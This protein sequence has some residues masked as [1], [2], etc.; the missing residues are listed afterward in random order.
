MAGQV[1]GQ[2][3]RVAERERAASELAVARDTALEASRLKS[4][5]L[6]MMSHEIRTPMNGVIGLNELLLGTRLDPHQRRLAEAAQLSGSALL[7]II[8]DVLDFSKI[9]AG[10]LALEA[11]EFEL[12]PVFDQVEAT[13][14]A[15]AEDKGVDLAVDVAPDVPAW[16]VGDPTRLGQVVSN[17]VSNAV[18]F[19]PAGRVDVHVGVASVEGKTILLEVAVVDTGIGIDPAQLDRL[20]EPFRQ[21]D[22][23]TTRLH[24]GSGLGLAISRRLVTALGGDLRV[25]SVP[26]EGS[27]FWFTARF[28]QAVE[29]AGGTPVPD[30]AVVTA[31]TDGVRPPGAALRETPAHV[32]VV[33]DNQVNQMVAAGLLSVLGYTAEV[34]DDGLAAVRRA[35]EAEYD[36]IL[37]D[38]RMPQIDGYAAAR[39]IRD[40]E[41]QG[42]RVP[43]IAMTA[44]AVEGEHERCLAAG[45]DDFIT[46]PVSSS[47]L[48]EVL[49]AHLGRPSSAGPSGARNPNGSRPAQ[50]PAGLAPRSAASGRSA[51]GRPPRPDP[52]RPAVELGRLEELDALGGGAVALVTRAVDKFV[53]SVPSTLTA[54]RAALAAGAHSDL[55]D[56][57]HRFRGSALNLGA[58]RVAELSL[59]LELLGHAEAASRGPGLVEQ[60][61]RAAAE[62][63]AALTEHRL[64][65]TAS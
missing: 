63:A 27:R 57:A 30:G 11:V 23:S 22:A 8:N 17:L 45:M 41:P 60:L 9:E 5:F 10:E 7:G 65:R 29:D 25:S 19:T 44:S 50:V 36:A 42:C 2:L 33:E 4:E 31:A 46:K 12:R 3:V 43:I 38:L 39:M 47:R 16:L 52:S 24:G 14:A 59:E 6:A 34:V 37:M 53:Q 1:A 32:L 51:G 49:A 40:Q 18:K 55:T 48:G 64:R 58:V 15:T 13:L 56:L 54:L 21:A 62:A 20:F 28:L 61:E 26:G 35:R